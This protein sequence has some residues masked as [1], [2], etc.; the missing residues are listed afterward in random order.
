MLGCILSKCSNLVL[1]ELLNEVTVL[2]GLTS[3]GE[4]CF[5]LAT[6]MDMA[7]K[8]GFVLEL[9]TRGLGTVTAVSPGVVGTRWALGRTV[10][11]HRVRGCPQVLPARVHER[12]LS[13]GLGEVCRA[14]AHTTLFWAADM[15][16]RIYIIV[17]GFHWS[18]RSLF[19]FW[20]PAPPEQTIFYL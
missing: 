16:F 18:R 13:Q 11:A 14:Q 10:W 2:R 20:K 5:S 8:M 15:N 6:T 9:L 17:V 12:S 7:L 19:Q 3:W 4:N 1:L